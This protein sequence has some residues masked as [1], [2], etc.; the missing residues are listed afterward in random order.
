M[1]YHDTLPH[2]PEALNREV[3]MKQLIRLLEDTLD[4]DQKTTVPV[5]VQNVVVETKFTPQAAERTWR[6][7]QTA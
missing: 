2:T 6:A 1:T 3:E 7:S 4:D 5:V